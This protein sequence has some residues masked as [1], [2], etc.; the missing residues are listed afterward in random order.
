MSTLQ[1]LPWCA[2]ATTYQLGN[3]RLIRVD[4]ETP[5][6]GA[7]KTSEVLI[8]KFIAA[9]LDIEGRKV[10]PCAL[11]AFKGSDPARDLT[12]DELEESAEDVQ[13]ATFGSL[14]AR[15]FFRSPY[16]NSTCFTR[17]VQ[18]FEDARGIAISSRRRDGGALAAW[19]ASQTVFGIP[20]QASAVREVVIDEALTSSLMTYREGANP[21]DWVRWQNAVDCF[22]FANSDDSAIPLHVEW[23]MVAAAFQRLVGARSDADAI[24]SAF[25]EALQPEDP[26]LAGSA[27][28]RPESPNAANR[29]LRAVWARE[30]YELRGEYAHGRLTTNRKHVWTPFEH[31]LLAAIAFPLLVKSLLAESSAYILTDSDWAQVDAFES[32]LNSNFLEPPHDQ[33]NSWDW[34]WTRLESKFHGNRRLRHIVNEAFQRVRDGDAS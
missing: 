30:F 5:I 33:Q 26:I 17:Y 15:R 24:A 8:R 32:L 14:A 13:L 22:N 20:P 4:A 25:E 28:R 29:S 21:G 31:M 12:A 23:V 9:Y 27:T 16:S 3:V 11:V 18:R 10:S 34:I 2:I 6:D 7:S 1:I 19:S